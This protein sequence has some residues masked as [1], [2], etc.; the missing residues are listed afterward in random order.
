MEKTVKAI[1]KVLR[2]GDA[3]NFRKLRATLDDD[4]ALSG[5]EFKGVAATGFDF[6]GLDLSNTE[7]SECLLERA[8]FTEGSLE[9]AYFHGCTIVDPTFAGTNMAGWTLEG[10]TV[11]RAMMRAVALDGAEIS[12]SEFVECE[13]IEVK[14]ADVSI[15]AVTF[16]NCKLGAKFSEGSMT[17]V[18]LR[19]CDVSALELDGVDV[20][21]CSASG[22]ELP[23]GFEKLTGR[24]TRIG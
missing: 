18:T 20:S 13:L 9:G 6:S 17:A 5:E 24:R 3:A 19:D 14:G 1:H 10:S 7:W 22:P 2:E 8:N 12:G 16:A 11:K 4:A 21:G 23:S 15:E